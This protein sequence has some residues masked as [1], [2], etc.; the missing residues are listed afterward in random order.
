MFYSQALQKRDVFRP[1]DCFGNVV[2]PI[3][4]PSRVSLQDNCVG[5]VVDPSHVGSKEN[6]VGGQYRIDQELI[7]KSFKVCGQ[8]PTTGQSVTK[9]HN[10]VVE[11]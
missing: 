4:D 2:D 7:K 6:C 8:T 3:C 11:S 1:I 9:F 10:V 5:S